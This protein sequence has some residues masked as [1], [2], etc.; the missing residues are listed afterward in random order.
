MNLIRINF[1]NE[2]SLIHQSSKYTPKS[3]FQKIDTFI[4]THRSTVSSISIKEVQYTNPIATRPLPSCYPTTSLLLPCHTVQPQA[5]LNHP[6]SIS[7]SCSAGCRAALPYPAPGHLFP[8]PLRPQDLKIQVYLSTRSLPSVHPIS[9]PVAA[10]GNHPYDF[11]R[12]NQSLAA[13]I[14]VESPSCR[15]PKKAQYLFTPPSGIHPLI[16]RLLGNLPHQKATQA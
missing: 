11:I 12:V 2:T 1:I 9:Q 16:H 13:F 7:I 6:R 4:S 3:A 15:L 10:F 5:A 8:S 14:T